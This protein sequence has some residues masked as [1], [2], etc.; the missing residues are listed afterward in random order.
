MKALIGT[1]CIALTLAV[2]SGAALGQHSSETRVIDARVQKVKLGGTIDLRVKQGP[3]ASL[4]ITGDQRY[5]PKVTTT[6][7][8]DTLHI[9]IENDR[10]FN[11]GKNNKDQL[12]VELTLP[13]FNE[14]VSQGVGSASITGFTGEQ[15]RLSLDGAGTVTLASRYRSINATLGGVGNMALGTTDSERVELSLRGAGRIEVAGQSKLLRAKL[16]GIGSLEARDLRADTVELKM[17]GLGSA[18]VYARSSADLVLNGLGSATV[19]GKPSSRKSSA[20]GLG[21]VSWE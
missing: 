13:G 2:T 6:Q 9:D 12:R 16:G 7:R 3:A 19:Y 8:G 4:V 11:F 1:V 17:S 21:S 15:I 20:S 18:T 10:H 5:V 14:L